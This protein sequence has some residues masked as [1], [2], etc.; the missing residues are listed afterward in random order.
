MGL[1]EERKID[2]GE[3][4]LSQKVLMEKPRLVK[5]QT[6]KFNKSLV[7]RLNTPETGQNIKE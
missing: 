2:G 1:Y 3:G 5:V 4:I 7:M 6:N